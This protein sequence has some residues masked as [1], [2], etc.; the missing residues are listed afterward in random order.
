M[1]YQSVFGRVHWKPWRLPS[2]SIVLSGVEARTINAA[3][4]LQVSPR[5]YS[6]RGQRYQSIRVNGN[7]LSPWKDFTSSV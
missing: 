6:P 7:L 1:V 5:N 3:I 2:D 4:S